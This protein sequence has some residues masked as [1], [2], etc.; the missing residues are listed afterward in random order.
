[1]T[2]TPS[3]LSLSWIRYHGRSADLADRLG[4]SAEFVSVGR[5][6]QR[7]AV[8]WRYPI[9]LALTIRALRRHRAD[10]LIVMA[11]PLPLVVLAL[12]WGRLTSRPVLIDAHSA[13]V[14]SPRTR[15]PRRRFALVA[16]FAD[17]VLVTRPELA[18]SLAGC[19]VLA[20][21]DPPVA[22]PD[23]APDR[24]RRDGLPLRVVFPCSW[25]DDE[26]VDDVIEAA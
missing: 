1:M 21:D 17:L 4:A 10:A 25:Y 23:I 15:R 2:A 24:A 13:A 18:T 8:L 5:L 20:L 3:V 7:V 11:P 6:G 14:I 22:V 19:R 26:P 16:R 9:Q 12:V